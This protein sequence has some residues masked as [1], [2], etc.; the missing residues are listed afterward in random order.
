MVLTRQ[1]E[2]VVS[3]SMHLKRAVFLRVL[4]TVAR[5]LLFR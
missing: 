1:R 3:A 4:T 5:E 2:K